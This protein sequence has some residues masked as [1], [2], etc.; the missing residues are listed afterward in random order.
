MNIFNIFNFLRSKKYDN[1]N[2]NF[3]I[4]GIEK[5]SYNDFMNMKF[6]INDID[7]ELLDFWY[8][9][10]RQSIMLDIYGGADEI[11]SIC[12]KTPKFK[13]RINNKNNYKDAIL[14]QLKSF[15]RVCRIIYNN[16]NITSGLKWE[17]KVAEWEMLDYI[18]WNNER[19][20]NINTIMEWFNQWCFDANLE[21]I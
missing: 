10:S 9:R 5:I 12:K 20:Y 17:V 2:D 3:K 7:K 6:D 18:L 19:N 1:H 4:F 15:H 13:D 16:P 8:K 21:L 11:I 14:T